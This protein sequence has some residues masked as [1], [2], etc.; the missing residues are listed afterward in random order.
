MFKDLAVMVDQQQDG[1]DT[2]AANITD[3]KQKAE[4][5]AAQVEEVTLVTLY[6]PAPACAHPHTLF[7]HILSL[8]TPPHLCVVVPLQR[9]Q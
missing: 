8:V 3:A 4:E 5:G 1:I 7:T 2:I 9:L 6:P